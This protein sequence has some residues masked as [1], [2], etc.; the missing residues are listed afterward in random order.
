MFCG[1]A[2]SGRLRQTVAKEVWMSNIYLERK[3]REGGWKATQNGITI[4]EGDTQVETGTAARRVSPDD[5]ILAERVEY[6]KRGK[7]DKWRRF[8]PPS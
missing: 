7:P 5:P 6:T 1:L 8:Y 2:R 4:A 3:K